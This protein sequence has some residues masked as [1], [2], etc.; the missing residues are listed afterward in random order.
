MLVDSN[1][2]ANSVVTAP[3]TVKLSF[4]EKIAPAQSGVTL[5]MVD[6][7]AVST[8]ISVSDDGKTVTARPTGPFMAGQWTATWHAAGED[9]L[10]SKGSFSFTVK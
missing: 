2:A 9:G 1:P 8:K 7:M 10:A 3:R 4:S 6:G 5:S